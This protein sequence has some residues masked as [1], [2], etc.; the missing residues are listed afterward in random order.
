MVVVGDDAAGCSMPAAPWRLAHHSFSASVWFVMSSR[1]LRSIVLAAISLADWKIVWPQLGASALAFWFHE[2]SVLVFELR[3]Q[4]GG[5]H[6]S[7]VLTS[8]T[9]SLSSS[10]ISFSARLNRCHRSS[11]TLPR[12]SSEL[13]AALAVRIWMMRWMSSTARRSRAVRKTLSGTLG[14]FSE[15]SSGSR[16]SSDR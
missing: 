16:W 5:E 7:R 2:E 15:P 1:R 9:T 6:S 8:I 4:K 3:L 11:P 13:Q 14:A 12:A 10:S